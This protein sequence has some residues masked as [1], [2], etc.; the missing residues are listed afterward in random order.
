MDSDNKKIEKM[1]VVVEGEN[2]LGATNLIQIIVEREKTPE[3]RNKQ[4]YYCFEK[5]YLIK[6]WVIKQYK[7]NDNIYELKSLHEE[8]HE[9]KDNDIKGENY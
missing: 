9:S 8:T 4:W 1:E 3:F 6:Y 7:I 2:P 5:E